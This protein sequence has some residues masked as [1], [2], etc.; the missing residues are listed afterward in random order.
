MSKMFWQSVAIA[1]S[2]VVA[3][4]TLAA[5]A[6]A[7]RETT[8]YHTDGLGSVVAASNPS[9]ELLWRKE[10]APFGDQIDQTPDTEKLGYTGKPHD[11]VLGLTNLGARYYDPHLGRFMSP[12]PVG[13]VESNPV[14]FNRYAYVNNNPY[15]YVDP[16]GELLNFAAK[17][18]LD[19]GVNIAINYVTT[20][21]MNVGGALKE[22]AEADACVPVGSRGTPCWILPATRASRFPERS[23]VS[24]MWSPGRR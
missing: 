22:S 15:K 16:D 8:Y 20:G 11:T 24:R 9:G 19:V 17:F 2:A 4:I 5:P 3:L 14:S 23:V 7:A 12:D 13:S 6:E 18:V 10:Y 21:E 1:L